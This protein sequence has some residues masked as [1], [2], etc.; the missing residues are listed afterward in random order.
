M[1]QKRDNEI[2]PPASH[3]SKASVS[4]NS[5]SFPKVAVALKRNQ[6]L[7]NRSVKLI[8]LNFLKKFHTT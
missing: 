4:L 3:N 8:T 6:Q 2:L 7:Y 1:F 5:T